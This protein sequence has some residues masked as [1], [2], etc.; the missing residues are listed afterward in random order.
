MKEKMNAIRII[1]VSE[2]PLFRCGIRATLESMGDCV[3]VGESTDATELIEMARE[4]HPDVVLIDSGLSTVNALDIARR[5]H[6]HALNAAMFIFASSED[7]EQ[8]F[9][10]IKLG[11]VA[12]E[13]RAITPE[14]LVDK[15]R[16]VSHGEYLISND[17]LSQVANISQPIKTFGGLEVQ[18]HE[19]VASVTASPLSTREIEILEFIA[20]GNSNKEIAKVL[21]ISDQTVKNHITSILK[22]LMVND[23]TAAVV[24]ALRQNWIKLEDTV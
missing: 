11:A 19:I 14:A 9:Q 16:K 24:Y 5:F 23:R 12:Y 10:F 2:L 21:E 7:E 17:V 22:K 13:S 4:H 6:Q 18:E 20:R 8:L 15:V 1:I 3:V